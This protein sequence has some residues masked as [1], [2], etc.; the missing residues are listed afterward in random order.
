VEPEANPRATRPPAE[1]YRRRLDRRGETVVGY[2]RIESRLSVLRMAIVLG[3]LALGWPV[4]IAQVLSWY[5]LL[6][7]VAAFIAAAVVHERVVRRR[8]RAERAVAYYQRGLERLDDRWAGQGRSGE[9]FLD[10][11][12]PYA[13]DLDLFGSGSLF[14]LL[15]RARTRIGERTLAGWLLQPASAEELRARQQ[16]VTELRDKND[17]RE[18]LA[19]IGEEIRGHDDPD[20][21]RAWGAAPALLTE[22]WPVFVGSLISLFIAVGFLAWIVYPWGRFAFLGAALSAVLFAGAFVTR[23]RAVLAGVDHAEQELGSLAQILSRL[24]VEQFQSPL[25]RELR[26]ALDS[27]GEPP[28]RRIASLARMVQLRDSQENMLFKPFAA[29]LLLGTQLA[30]AMERWR[31]VSGAAV[32]RWVDAVGAIEALCSLAT[33][34]FEHPEQPFPEIVDVGPR[35]DAVAV[36][37]PLLP[38]ARC[39]RNDV[40]LDDGQRLLLI[41]GSNMAGKSTLMR[42]V[43]V[44]VVLALAGGTVRAERLV[45]SPMRIGACMRVM[46]SLQDGRSH[47]YA[48]ITRLRSI[49]DL[50]DRGDP[51]LFL[52]DEIL[53]G[54]NSHDR[55]IGAEALIRGLLDRGA[56]GLVTTHDLALAVIADDLAPRAINVHFEDRLEG[57]RIVFDYRLHPGVV[58]KGN[59][60]ALM[61]A[62]GLKV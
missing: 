55:R 24:E 27:E 28:S 44:N 14:Q 60:L 18:E 47:F 51:L 56:V 33:Q 52:L 17:L 59:A 16:A 10:A 57:E 41:S 46:D 37:H 49:V 15:C 8:R 23:V 11:E 2:R 35:L 62:V 39:V 48:E 30:F 12:H 25:L 36:G 7:P 53:H 54:T 26:A 22:R 20:S 58:R 34:A 50:G 3:G 6:L 32:A 29:A 5:W 4:V 45:I 19:V 61:R 1:V 43:G 13:A 38:D 21:L 40:R 42:T 9:K 31:A